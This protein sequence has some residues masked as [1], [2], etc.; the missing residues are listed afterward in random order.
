MV[1]DD[2]E[3][4]EGL[5][6]ADA[7]GD[8]AAAEALQLVDRADDAVALEL[9]ELLPDHRVADAGRR[10]DDALFVEVVAAVAEEV[11][12]D[13]RVDEEWVAVGGE[14]LQVV[15]QGGFG[16]GV[17]GQAGPLGVEPLTEQL[18]FVGR[19]GR[20]DQAQRI[21][22]RQ[23]ESIGTERKRAEKHL[24]RTCLA[25]AQDERALRDCAKRAPYL[26]LVLE[27]L[28]KPTCKP[29]RLQTVAR[30]A[31]GVRAQKRKFRVG[32]RQ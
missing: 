22:R 20:L 15:N 1:L 28:R 32:G 5:A 23:P 27:P 24:Q 3:R 11:V 19:L 21:A 6:E 17:G 16:A 29:A 8:D 13:E 31:I 26:G 9:V 30:G 14:R 2:R 4:L 25:I 10:L 7:V 18:R 12:Q